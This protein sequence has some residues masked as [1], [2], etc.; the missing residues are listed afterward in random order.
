ALDHISSTPIGITNFEVIQT[1]GANEGPRSAGAPTANAGPDAT[2][3]VGVPFQLQGFVSFAT[4]TTNL[5]KLYSGPTNLTFA[6]TALTNT[7]V[8]FNTNGIYTLMMSADDGIHA[9][10]FDAVVITAT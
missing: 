3:T 7:T 4:P 5:W 2:A 6:N 8:T 10:A 9:V 1:T